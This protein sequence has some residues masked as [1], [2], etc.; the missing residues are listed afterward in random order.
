MKKAIVLLS[1]GIDSATTLYFALDSGYKVHS[2]TFEYGQ[3]HK[4]EVDSARHIAKLTKSPW[5]LLKIQLPWRGSAL[6]DKQIQLPQKRLA[7]EMPKDIPVTYVAARNMIFLSFAASW[8]EV[9]GAEAIFIGA[10]EIDFSGYPDCRPDFYRAFHQVI[11]TGTKA[12]AE[13][14]EL[15]VHIE[16]PLIDKTKGE[17]VKMGIELNVPYEFTWSCYKGGKKPC[18]KCDACI[19]RAKAFKQAWIPD[20]LLK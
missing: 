19:L 9:V 14:K 18:C 15:P 11:K 10:N 1:G 5:Q 7:N 13:G 4:K 12:G 3:R 6:L 17:I 2:L 16:T 20:P 8:A